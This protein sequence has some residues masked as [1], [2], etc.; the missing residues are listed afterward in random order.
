M[1]SARQIDLTGGDSVYCINA[2]QIERAEEM[3]AGDGDSSARLRDTMDRME[4]DLSR[5]ER[6]ALAMLLL[7]RLNAGPIG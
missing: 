5:N 1:N 4:A 3:Y 6:A 2:Y 7:Q